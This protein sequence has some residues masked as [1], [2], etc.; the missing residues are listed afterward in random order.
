MKKCKWDLDNIFIFVN[1]FNLVAYLY[2]PENNY[3]ENEKNFG[4]ETRILC[5]AKE[6]KEKCKQNHKKNLTFLL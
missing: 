2:I 3:N 1:W 4:D 5:K 6:K